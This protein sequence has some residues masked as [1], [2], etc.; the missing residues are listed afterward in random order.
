MSDPSKAVFLSYASQD[1]DAAR[2]ICEAL[3]AAGVEVWFDQSEL[4]GGDAWDAK[5]RKQ[6]KECALF[7]PVISANTQARPE[8]YFRL[9]WKLADRRTDLIGKAKAFLLPVCIDDTRDGDADV[10]DSFLA[11][12]WTRLPNGEL[13]DAFCARV[14]TL[15]AGGGSRDV[16]SQPSSSPLEE[17]SVRP[18]KASRPTLTWARPLTVVTALVVFAA[19]A[20]WQPWRRGNHGAEV[21]TSGKSTVTT[22]SETQQLL[23]KARALFEP[24]DFASH[25]DF[26][27]AEQLLKHATELEPTNAEIW[28]TYALCA[29]GF[30]SL[31]YDKSPAR[32]E[33]LRSRAEHAVKL[34]PDSFRARLAQACSF[35]FQETTRAEAERLARELAAQRPADAFCGLQHGNI[36]K[37][38]TG[39]AEEALGIFERVAALPLSDELSRC[40]RAIAHYSRALMLNRL[41]RH[42]E[43]EAAL[44]EAL[45]VRPDYNYAQ[46]LKIDLLRELHGNLP[47][48]AAAL[49][50]L[51][52]AYLLEDRGATTACLVWLWSRE[53]DK[54]LSILA[55]VPREV[56]EG[57]YHSGPRDYLAGQAHQIAGH[58]ES[59]QA[60]WRAALEVTE[61]QLALDASSRPWLA[62]K[63]RLLALL[64]RRAEAESALTLYQQSGPPPR[65]GVTTAT[66]AIHAALGRAREVANFFTVELKTRPDAT[67]ANLVRYDPALDP[68]RDTPE[69][70][71]LLES[72]AAKAAVSPS[73]A[74]PDPK[75]IAVLPFANLSTEKENEF[76]ADGVQDD[77]ITNLAKVRDLTV[78]SRTSTLAYRDSAARNLK[79]IA[80]DLGVATVLEGSVRR[81]GTKV[82]MNAQL[83][84]ART[85][86]HLWADS[87]D[88]DAS[89]PFA[90][91]ADVAQKIAAALKATLTPD[92]RNLL[93][94]RP[95]ENAAAYEYYLQ[96]KL[97][98]AGLYSPS[99]AADWD[100]VSGLLEQATA[101]DPKFAPAHA[102]LARTH[103][104]RFFYYRKDL[105]EQRERAR[106]RLDVAR[107]LAPDA[108]ETRTAEGYF[109]YAC[110][111]DYAVAVRHLERAVAEIPSDARTWYYLGLTKR[112]L[113]Q[114]IEG[115]AAMERALQLDPRDSAIL[116]NLMLSLLQLRRFGRVV[117]LGRQAREVVG[118]T[119]LGGFVA[120][121]ARYEIDGDRE[122]LLAGC[123]AWVV[124][125]N[126]LREERPDL[127]A[128]Y[129]TDGLEGAARA[130]EKNAGSQRA[131]HQAL[132]AHLLGRT[133]EARKFARIA[134]AEA[135][136]GHAV[137]DWPHDREVRAIEL[138]VYAGQPAEA[139]ARAR[140]LQPQLHGVDDILETNARNKLGRVYC[141]T[142]VREEALAI[143]RQLTTGVSAY[144]ATPRMVRIDPCWSKLADDPRFEEILKTAKPL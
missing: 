11:V 135:E 45:A 104:A 111:Q 98:S 35:R 127:I 110:L 47:A 112:R 103:A 12:Q 137:L 5:I 3:R 34:A 32:Y 116:S 101:V 61:R 79:K 71:A 16:A 85:D 43:A 117:T 50:K 125:T 124:P 41:Q 113:G 139:L 48:A 66:W 4:R 122:A 10:P 118:G 68:I 75:S 6:I 62:W 123:R 25:D 67:L 37:N 9:E 92:E 144:P 114:P 74:T 8:G 102:L 29:Y 83:I 121:V 105:P 138:L 20:F 24:W 14:R 30:L 28:S 60:K 19:F 22:M 58:A 89:D 63:A 131:H 97:L 26:K 54:C 49:A 2:R 53:P 109:A 143:L 36:L 73:A 72:A 80:A 31:G 88:G 23:A 140:S 76:F 55:G 94:R 115:V 142:G 91:Q 120:T 38:V 57:N 70:K 7:V 95:T 126:N 99:P 87:F 42:S 134:A 106:D 130:A 132:F 128:A 56:I 136:T 108:P 33:A 93:N 52:A 86:A 39:R 100:R 27:L 133:E 21:T 46:A 69:I 13:A 81:I 90:L 51:P 1:A 64:G 82:H 17:N 40:Y 18:G 77:V 78:I 84:D 107:K 15:L 141:L 44:D 129:L 119:G 59:A 96:A 65:S